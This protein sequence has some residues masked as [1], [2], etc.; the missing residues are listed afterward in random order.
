METDLS[1][2]VS[3]DQVPTEMTL[4]DGGCKLQ[5]VEILLCKK[6]G[7]GLERGGSNG[8]TTMLHKS[9]HP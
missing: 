5:E 7:W 8:G 3:P 9:T 1:V 6:V 2:E 4:N